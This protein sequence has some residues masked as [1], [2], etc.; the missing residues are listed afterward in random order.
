M[1]KDDIYK[2]KVKAIKDVSKIR[3]S[4]EEFERLLEE[5]KIKKV[6]VN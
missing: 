4:Q 3:A 5:T 1:D 2:E 6:I